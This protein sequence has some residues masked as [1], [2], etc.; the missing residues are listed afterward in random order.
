MLLYLL[1]FTVTANTKRGGATQTHCTTECSRLFKTVAWADCD[2]EHTVFSLYKTNKQK[3]Y[4]KFPNNS[5]IGYHDQDLIHCFQTLWHILSMAPE[6]TTQYLSAF[7]FTLSLC[8]ISPGIRSAAIKPNIS[9]GTKDNMYYI[10][11]LDSAGECFNN[12]ERLI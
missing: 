4:Q 3:P 6:K 1:T 10:C 2:R 5:Q 12:S 7:L 9:R 11:R 8:S